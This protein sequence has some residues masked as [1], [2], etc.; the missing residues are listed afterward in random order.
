[1]WKVGLAENRWRSHF[2]EP[3]FGTVTHLSREWTARF[4]RVGY[5]LAFEKPTCTRLSQPGSIH[6]H[7]RGR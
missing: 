1:M 2:I 3:R 5:T 7:Q 4:S 6:L